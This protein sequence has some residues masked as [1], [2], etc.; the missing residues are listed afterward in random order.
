MEAKCGDYAA[1]CE[2][3]ETVVANLFKQN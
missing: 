3:A 2:A 1:S